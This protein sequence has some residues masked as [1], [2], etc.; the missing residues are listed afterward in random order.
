MG[1]GMG[2]ST[3]NGVTAL[4]PLPI[5]VATF[6]TLSVAA[7]DGM[8]VGLGVSTG[9]AVSM[10]GVGAGGSSPDPSAVL[11]TGDGFE[12]ADDGIGVVPKGT[13]PSPLSLD[14]S[15]LTFVLSPLDSK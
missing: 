6:V 5:L 3:G 9:N 8:G 1:V 4:S 14:T 10:K 7:F 15:V 12:G 13:S 11:S 2:V